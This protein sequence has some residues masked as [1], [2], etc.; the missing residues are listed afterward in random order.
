MTPRI[1]CAWLV[2]L[3]CVAPAIGAA[4]A[5]GGKCVSDC[6]LSLQDEEGCCPRT[7]DLP[8]KDKKAATSCKTEAACAQECGDGVEKACAK[9]RAMAEKG[10]EQDKLESCTRLAY[11]SWEGLGGTRNPKE[12]VALHERACTA[13]DADS[14][15][16]ACFHAHNGVGRAPD[17]E[18]AKTLCA[19]MIELHEKACGEGAGKSCQALSEIHEHGWVSVK[20]DLA[21]SA[22]YERH[23]CDLRVASACRSL[24]QDLRGKDPPRA[25]AVGET[26]CELGDARACGL[27]ASWAE[28]VPTWTEK[29]R[30]R[31]YERATKL[32]DASCRR[33][34]V[35]ACTVIAMVNDGGDAA[36]K[37]TSR[38]Y[39]RKAGD[40][41]HTQCRQGWK[42]CYEAIA[43]FIAELTAMD[44]A[45]DDVSLS[46]DIADLI[47]GRIRDLGPAARR[48]CG[49]GDRHACTMAGMGG[50]EDEQNY[51]EKAVLLTVLQCEAGDE[52]ACQELAYD[53]IGAYASADED[54]A[55]GRGA[56][57]VAKLIT[58]C[59]AGSAF[60]C[61]AAGAQ[62]ALDGEF[63]EQDSVRGRKLMAQGC[64][65]GAPQCAP[66]NAIGGI[67]P[68]MQPT[69]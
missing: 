8:R 16:V 52:Q 39:A 22:D 31:L 57:A 20:A 59:N 66:D 24:A 17:A 7:G 15:R 25:I 64:L 29:A 48:D 26:A 18:R 34:N 60:A 32:K 51:A 19:R 13:G 11:V 36:A 12:S 45:G 67:L 5:W 43:R 62:Y 30:A 3:A 61:Y 68:H 56:R 38:R 14:C 41:F 65:N 10:C 55:K 4:P 35:V 69:F 1:R 23:A 6:A 28:R 40:L 54:D 33:G 47:I 37:A 44:D 63:V 42:P 49:R 53:P 21:L 2:G 9:L 46:D 50:M 27:A 58:L